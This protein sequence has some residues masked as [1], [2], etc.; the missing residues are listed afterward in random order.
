MNDLEIIM[1]RFMMI[2]VIGILIYNKGYQFTV[3]AIH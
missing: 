1:Y 3:N 2:R